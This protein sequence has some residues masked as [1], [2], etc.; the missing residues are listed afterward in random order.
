MRRRAAPHSA[1]MLRGN[2]QRAD[3]RTAG[4]E[5]APIC[6]LPA[7]SATSPK[8]AIVPPYRSARVL[9]LARRTADSPQLIDAVARRAQQGPC[10]FTL[11]VPAFP[12]GPHEVG[13]A[14]DPGQ[15]AAERRI[16]DAVPVLSRAAGSEVVAVIGGNEPFAA[17]CDALDLLGFDEVIVS[18]LPA[19]LS[20]WLHLELPRKIRALG[21]PVTEVIGTAV[22][23][24]R[25][26]AA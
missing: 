11:L 22:P 13:G 25:L 19:R 15:R 20:R 18:M 14:P 12:H 6:V 17:V 9:I 21:I 1:I 24:P 26:P 2:G 7:V 16:A 8:D 10:N 23:A 4:N 5:S 3:T